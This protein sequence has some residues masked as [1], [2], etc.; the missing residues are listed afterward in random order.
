MRQLCDGADGRVPM[1]CLSVQPALIGQYRPVG[2]R[3]SFSDISGVWHGNNKLAHTLNVRWGTR[4]N[5]AKLITG[6]TDYVDIY[7]DGAEKVDTG[8]FGP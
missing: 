8:G 1:T 4:Q 5:F 2:D 3:S 6:D 7:K